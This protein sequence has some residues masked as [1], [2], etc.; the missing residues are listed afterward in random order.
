M[1][2]WKRPVFQTG[3]IL[4]REILES[5]RDEAAVF[6]D[7][8]YAELTDGIIKPCQVQVLNGEL[9]VKGGLIKWAGRLYRMTGP[10]RIPYVPAE[11]WRILKIRFLPQSPS[12]D[13]EL[14]QTR[15]F[16]D[17]DLTLAE[18]ETE[19]CRFKLKAGSRLR[20]DYVDFYDLDTEFDTLNLLHVSYAGTD[21]PTVSPFMT[22]YFAK[23][24]YPLTV[25]MSFDN[26]FAAVCL[27]SREPVSRELILDYIGI[28]LGKQQKD[29]NH[30][31]NRE[32]YQCLAAIL[33]DIQRGISV[34]G[35]S[36]KSRDRKII[37][38]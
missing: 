6:A 30:L 19:L 27:N 14:Y 35:Y 26:A 10:V 29:L 9:E 25:G 16:L 22:R 13:F 18:D 36:R 12:M 17:D 8:Y 31:S 1:Y 38:D 34:D 23:E 15:L 4:S 5:V 11:E 28:R 20:Q 32:I 7:L 3:R 21:R 24:A 2:T 37:V 33:E